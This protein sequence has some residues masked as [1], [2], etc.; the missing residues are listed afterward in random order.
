[1]WQSAGGLYVEKCEQ[2]SYCVRV[3]GQDNL[4]VR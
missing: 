2:F 3:R 4:S 1:M